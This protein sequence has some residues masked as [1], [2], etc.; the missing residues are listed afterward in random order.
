MSADRDRLDEFLEPVMDGRPVAWPHADSDDLSAGEA[1]SIA[2]LEE[3]SRI[4]RF[5]RELQRSV[6]SRPAGMAADTAELSTPSPALAAHPS[7]APGTA[8]AAAPGRAEPLFRWGHLEALELVGRGS[9]GEVYRAIDTRLEREVALKLRRAGST[10]AAG[11]D[12]RFLAEARGLARVRHPNVLVVYGADMHDGKIGFWTDFVPGATLAERLSEQGPLGPIEM[13]RVGLDLCRALAAVHAAGLVHGD[14]K[15]TN[16]MVERDGRVVLMDFGAARP[17]GGEDQAYSVF[18]TPL[19]MAPEILAGAAPAPA[20]DLYSLGALLFQLASGHP[21]YEATSFADLR[22]QME[23]DRRSPL[24]PLRPDLPDALVAVIEHALTRD[25]ALRYQSA[26]DMESALLVAIEPPAAPRHSLPAEPDLLIGREGDLALL[27]RHLDQGARLVTLLGPAGIGKTRLAVHHGWHALER[28]PGG[29]WFCDLSEARQLE[30]IATAVSGALQV[31]LGKANPVEQLGRAIAGHGR[32]L[33]VLDNF[34]QV[35]ELAPDT[36]ERW[37]ERAPDARFVVTSRERLRVRGEVVQIVAPLTVEAAI[38]LFAERARQQHAGANLDDPAAAAAVHELVELV[39][40]IPLAIELAAARIRVMH[41]VEIIARMRERFRVL[42]ARRPAAGG[43]GDRHAT[44]E[45]AIDGSWELLSPWEKA[46]FMQSSVFQ[47]GFNLEAAEHVLDLSPW[48]EAPWVV[49]VV[50]ALVDKSLLRTWTAEAGPLGAPEFRTGMYAS[51]QEYAQ[52]RLDE[53]G[54]DAVMQAE[55][56][57][58]RWYARHGSED[59]MRS[60]DGREDREC[61]RRLEA[62]FENLMAA[63][64]RAIRRGDPGTAAATYQAAGVVLGRRGPHA[65]S[66]AL[67]RE[68]ITMSLAPT[69]HIDTLL[70]LGSDEMRVGDGGQARQRFDLA[71]STSREIGDRRRE[72]IALYELAMVQRGEGRMDEA[73]TT[74]QAALHILRDQGDWRGEIHALGELGIQ[75]LLQGRLDEARSLIEGALAIVRQAG[76]RGLENS[77]LGNLAIIAAEQGRLDE[78]QTLYEAALAGQREMRSRANESNTLN[79]LANLLSDQGRLADARLHYETGLAV[80]REIGDRR[81]EGILLSNLGTLDLEEGLHAEA[82]VHF[83]AGLAIA[84]E[85]MSRRSEG[86]AHENLGSLNRDEGR[87]EEARRH[88]DAALAIARELGNPRM[89]GIVLGSLG[90][91]LTDQGRFAEARPALSRGEELLAGLGEQTPL[92]ILLCTRAEMEARA[93]DPPAADATLTRAEALAD[94]AGA[95]PGS[96]LRRRLARLRSGSR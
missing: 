28:W 29:V 96:L 4:A 81:L 51:L 47:G 15:A 77:M 23:Q 48:P 82:R 18:G 30:G 87:T 67:G 21:P 49:D 64:R 73:R 83:E 13:V 34:E 38:R 61:L 68:V 59:A 91:L 66:A 12:E 40:G 54:A 65:A 78:A 93:G 88:L 76:G 35:A 22:T 11:G 71:L 63:C 52:A 9:F 50:Q 25:P 41:P 56:R 45:L 94:A 86:Y 89:E 79:N 46:A 10:S 37:L 31:P 33:V 74:C 6:P 92:G 39:D 84:Q 70:A 14:V 43:R 85:T 72:G 27:E 62:E 19:T 1:L 90:A 32:C 42:G 3:V 53:L 75:S 57:H 36:V 8:P 5:N 55:A 58:G 16:A 20:A 2:A 17:F 80:S 7:P 69:D 24:G 95:T 26:A 60:L 44:L